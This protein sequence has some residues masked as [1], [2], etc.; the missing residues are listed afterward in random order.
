MI[1]VLSKGHTI[2]RPEV[3]VELK[4]MDRKLFKKFTDKTF[5]YWCPHFKRPWP[6][7]RA[8]LDKRGPIG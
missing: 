3:I 7:L 6:D 8:R 2:T 4:N 1:G 5:D